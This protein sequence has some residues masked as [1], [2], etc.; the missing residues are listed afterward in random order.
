MRTFKR[1]GGR[2][3]MEL[4]AVEVELLTNLRDGLYATLE[5]G[6]DN[7]PA[8]ARLFPQAVT[9]DDE[10]DRELRHLLHNDLLAAK[11][12][13][14]DELVRLLERGTTTRGRRRVDLTAEEAMLVLGVLNDLRLAIGARIG[15]EQI[16]RRAL[17]ADDEVVASLAVMD[18]FAW[19]QEQLL[20]IVDPASV[21][22]YEEEG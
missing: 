4:T 1:H 5:D 17:D 20:A 12:G 22:H 10:A 13:A 2:I 8:R 21:T 11:L 18:H 3:R 15:I 14:L 16:D 6:P 7:D 19:W 9:G